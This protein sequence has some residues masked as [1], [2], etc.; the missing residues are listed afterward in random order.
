MAFSSLSV[1]LGEV[2]LQPA[3]PQTIS[4]LAA[5][6]NTNTLSLSAIG[7]ASAVAYGCLAFLKAYARESGDPQ[8]SARLSAD[9]TVT[10]GVS[11]TTTTVTVQI[12]L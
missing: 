9:K 1:H 11:S 8:A 5:A 7:G 2:F 12:A 4:A 10:I 3:R 6:I